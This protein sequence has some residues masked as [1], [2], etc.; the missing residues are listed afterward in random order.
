M[1]KLFAMVFT[2]ALFMTLGTGSALATGGGGDGK[3][4]G[5]PCPPASPGGQENPPDSAPN[6]GN[7]NG[8][9]GGG[10][11]TCEDGKANDKDGSKDDK[12]S[13]CQDPRDGDENGSDKAPEGN[14]QR[15]DLVLLTEDAKIVC[16]FFGEN[17]QFATQ[18]ADCRDALI[19]LPV[20]DV[21]GACVF[22]PPAQARGASV[23]RRVPALNLLGL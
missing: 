4:S 22:L 11:D 15:A 19:A 5:K 21:L 14:C 9:N 17:A 6:C 18:T 7:G 13:E 20:D 16:L 23:L 1:R 12:D 2:I 8:G 3:G 10:K